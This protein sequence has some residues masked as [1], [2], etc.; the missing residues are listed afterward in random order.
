MTS[1]GMVLRNLALVGQIQKVPMPEQM[2]PVF[3]QGVRLLFERWTA[4]QLA[5]QNEWG[6]SK[7]LEKANDLLLDVIDWFYHSK[8]RFRR[9]LKILTVVAR[10]CLSF[11]LL[12]TSNMEE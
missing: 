12:A 9:R 3:E 10:A 5:I 6:G 8:G 4:L 2:K 11:L 1:Q 7:S